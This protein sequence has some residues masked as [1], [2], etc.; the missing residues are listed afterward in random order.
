[1]NRVRSV[2]LPDVLWDQLA[3][4]AAQQGVSVSTVIVMALQSFAKEGGQWEK[5]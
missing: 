5:R 3:E 1:M 4:T 2:R